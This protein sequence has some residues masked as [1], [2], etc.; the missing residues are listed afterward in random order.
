MAVGEPEEP[1]PFPP[2]VTQ[3]AVELHEMASSSI[4]DDAGEL[5]C[6][7]VQVTPASVVLQTTGEMVSGVVDCM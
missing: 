2:T 3:S 5:S 4:Y 7:C 6:S 1:I